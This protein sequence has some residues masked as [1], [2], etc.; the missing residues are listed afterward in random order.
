MRKVK[1]FLNSAGRV[2]EPYAEEAERNVREMQNCISDVIPDRVKVFA[3]TWWGSVLVYMG[4]VLVCLVSG[5]FWA[6][7]FGRSEIIVAMCGVN[8]IAVVSICSSFL[9]RWDDEGWKFCPVCGE[10]T[11][12]GNFCDQCGALIAF[13]WLLERE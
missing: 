13:P 5:A 10:V 7:L 8:I 2:L 9:L 12:E 4:A 1:N 6:L 11:L 3:L